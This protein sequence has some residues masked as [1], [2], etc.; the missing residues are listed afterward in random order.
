MSKWFKLF[1]ILVLINIAIAR[2]IY[3][4]LCRLISCTFYGGKMTSLCTQVADA[5]W[6]KVTFITWYKIRLTRR[7]FITILYKL[8]FLFRLLLLGNALRNSDIIH[9][10]HWIFVIYL[11]FGNL[12]L[13]LFLY[14]CI[15]HIYSSAH[16][17][18]RRIGIDIYK[19]LS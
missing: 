5:Y 1:C 13:L 7:R 3:N 4:S 8:L 6:A 15:L 9:T 14:E 11:F 12:D 10:Y 18:L 2:R 17:K 16:F 19:F